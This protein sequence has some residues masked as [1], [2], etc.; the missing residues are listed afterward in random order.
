MRLEV[1]LQKG[2]ALAQQGDL[3]FRRAGIRFVALICGK[4]LPL[5]IWRQCHSK[6]SCSLSSLNLVLVL[7]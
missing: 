3:Y 7:T 1:R 4:N 2:E 6:G 5:G